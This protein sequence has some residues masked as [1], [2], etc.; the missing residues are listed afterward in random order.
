MDI[1][2]FDWRYSSISNAL[3]ALDQGCA[4][5]RGQFDDGLDMLEHAESLVGL[6]YVALQVYIGGTVA[7]LAE[8]FHGCPDAAVLRSSESPVVDKAGITYVESVWAA[9]NYFKHHDEW[10][11]WTR[12]AR[13]ETRVAFEK[14]GISNKTEFPCYEV[15]RRLNGDDLQLASLL[16]V[17][18]AW[19]E[20]WFAKLRGTAS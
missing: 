3:I 8:V 13:K 12:D 17:A 1:A 20:S 5:L 9:A 18:E 7:D 19:R 4:G 11:D 6:G 15:L 10:H 14:L 2:E 16:V